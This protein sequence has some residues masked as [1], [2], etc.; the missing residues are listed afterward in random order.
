M[1]FR[2]LAASA[3]VIALATAG[4]ASASYQLDITTSYGF[5]YGG[6][7]ATFLGGGAASPD[8]GFVTFTNSGTT[9]YVGQF[10]YTAI[11][12]F[13][14]DLS[15]N[16]GPVTL[17]PGA[18]AYEAIDSESSNVGG[19]NG[20]YNTVPQPGVIIDA[21]G[22]FGGTAVSLSVDDS[23]VHSG[24]SATNPYGVTLDN[25]VLQGGD[26]LG[27]DTGDG[28]EVAQAFGHYTFFSGGTVPEPATWAMMLVGVGLVGF[29]VRRRSRILAV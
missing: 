2:I 10:S 21:N 7:P 15:F 20:P 1:K 22:A 19:F 23:S 18:S 9:T 17:L 14:G 5:G 6:P 24:V 29:A 11:S 8:T 16:S 27:R 4:S 26:P 13:A 25:Y 28:F 3:A 12:N